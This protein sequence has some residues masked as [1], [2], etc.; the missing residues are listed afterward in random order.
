MGKK[1]KEKDPNKI[2]VGKF[3]AWQSRGIAMACEVM[4]LAY[5][6]IYCTNTM[7]LSAALVGTILMVSKIFDG[8]TDL[9]AGYLIDRTNTKIGRGR[10]YELAVIG[11][12]V[13]V[14]LMFSMPEAGTTMK[15]IWLFVMY[16]LNQSIFQTFLNANGTIYMIRAFGNEQQ[17]VKLNALGGLVVT[18]GA[19]VVNM[20]LP[21]TV[22]SMGTSAQGWSRMILYYCIPLLIISL[23]RFFFVKE[24]NRAEVE[25][26]Q[27]VNMK[28]VFTVLKTNKYIYFVGLLL[29]VYNMISNMGVGTYYFTY[30]VGDLTKM[31]ALGLISVLILVSMVFYT[32][33]LKKMTVKQ[34]IQ[35]GCILYAAGML[36]YFFAQGNV[37]MI[38]IASLVG[39]CGSLPI[40]YMNYQ[41]I[42]DCAS[43]NEWKGLPRLEG[44]MTSVTGFCSK[45]GSAVGVFILG[46]LLTASGFDG[47]QEV[48]P[49]SAIMMI[50]LLASL[51]P[52][53]FYIILAVVLC[54]YKLDDL[55]PQIRKDL[56]EKHALADVPKEKN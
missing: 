40:A 41:M 39:G 35:R 4:I 53:A 52:M 26:A 37:T 17:Y 7:G 38:I 18:L 12:W 44:T 46:I 25:S 45:I 51:I 3:W 1:T 23:M 54:F 50:R 19:V 42:I 29:L 55:M 34:L 20:M 47:M 48:Q 36:I 10:P 27:K 32:K 21:I 22:A 56:D 30:I 49:D 6:S 8:V 2:G 31:S 43:Y 33:L 15:A 16:T 9:F 24:E 11:A 14:W 13:T 28:E 5:I